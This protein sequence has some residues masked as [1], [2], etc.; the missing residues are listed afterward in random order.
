M[1]FSAKYLLGGRLYAGSIFLLC[2][3]AA[4][5]PGFASIH[6]PPNAPEEVRWG[7]EKLAAAL[8]EKQISEADAK[9]TVTI[10]ADKTPEDESFVLEKNA[11]AITVRGGGAVGAMYGLLELAEQ[12]HGG[13]AGAWPEIAASI[14]PERQRPFLA[15]RADN[16]FVHVDPFIFND[17]AMWRKYIDMLAQNRFNMIDM[18]GGFDLNTTGFPNLF[19][20]LITVPEYPKAGDKEL[21]AKN[22]ADFKAIVAYAKSRGVKVALMNYSASVNAPRPANTPPPAPGAPRVFPAPLV[23]PAQL[24]D[25][26][27]RATAELI[28]QVPDLYEIGFRIGETGQPARF[29]QDS[30]LKGFS[31]AKAT[32][33]RLYTRSW[34]TTKEQLEP[35]AKAATSG[36]DIE[37]KYNGEHLGL[38]YQAMQYQYGTYSYEH[39]LDV[40]KDYGIIWQVRADGTHH[41][42]AW[43]N[44]DFIRRTVHTFKLGDARGFTLEPMT[45]YYPVSAAVY[46]RSEEDKKT[47]D[48][49]WQKHWMWYFGWGRLGYNPEL[50]ES[51]IRRAYSDHFGKAGEPIYNA[52]Q[53]SSTIVPLVYAYRSV[54]ADQ[55]DYSPE[56]ETGYAENART[57]MG[58]RRP[59]PE[60][61]LQYAMNTPEDDRSF[62]GINTWVMDKIDTMADGRLGPFAVAELL[63]NASD[64]TKKAIAEIPEMDG[65]TARE[66]HLLKTDMLAAA[67]LGEYHADRI[68]GLTYFQHGWKTHSDGEYAQATKLLTQSREAWAKLSETVDTVY[69]PVNNPMRQQRNYEWKSQLPLLEKTDAQ[70]TDLWAGRPRGGAKYPSGAQS[71]PIQFLATDHVDNGGLNV[72]KLNYIV[73]P[74]K[75]SVTLTCRPSPASGLSRVVL[76]WKPLPSSSFWRSNDM[77]ENG[78]GNYVAVVP[79]TSEGLMYSVE[80]QESNGNARNFPLVLN[81]T[82]YRIIPPF[83]N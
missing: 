65:R 35:I 26:T 2:S 43:E 44:T 41:Y 83:A 25:Y 58:S 30:Y 51:T 5:Q 47:Y 18:H 77:I 19:P 52:M 56:T 79:L 6:L 22:L 81:E 69:A 70:A 73:A 39:Y 23:P 20:Y 64:A 71:G 13:T 45:A 16:I 48:Y 46:Y 36:F 82:P 66:W 15:I 40:P 33:L 75:K 21:Q 27:A 42:W 28:R 7:A 72:E 14:K 67:W 10:G 55:R 11:T 34:L 17:V 3:I 53:A 74:S 38:P 29:F 1:T 60:G 76:W 78:A 62:V 61:L 32:N 24:A 8:S 31:D 12:I 80:V 63:R 50:A 54:G 49:I 68:E 59:I 9:V 57:I 37:I 4:C